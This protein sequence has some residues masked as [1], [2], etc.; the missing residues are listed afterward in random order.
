MS[1]HN[2]TNPESYYFERRQEMIFKCRNCGGNV[3]YS[4]EKKGMYCPYCDSENQD[5]KTTVAGDIHVCP[6]CGGELNMEEHTSAARCPYCEN[7]IIFDERVN[8]IYEPRF[9]IPFQ[10][11]RE[12]VKKLLKSKFKRNIFAPVDFL[13]EAKLNSM[14]GNYVPFWLYDYDT[15]CE[16]KGEGTKIRTWRAGEMEY[17]ETSY[18]HIYRNMDIFFQKIPVDASVK[19]SDNIMDLMEPYQYEQLMEFKPDYMSGFQGEKYNMDSKEVAFRARGKMEA[20]SKTMLNQSVGGYVR[21]RTIAEDVHIAR[22]AANYALLPVWL[23]QYQYNDKDYP[24]YING[25]TGKIIGKTP[26]SPGKV[27]GYGLTLWGVLTVIM[28]SI[29]VLLNLL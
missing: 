3:I 23:Y 1:D 19:M 6:D 17:T 13:S 12:M 11:S 20:D 21:I 5:D 25:Q 18:Y 8:G 16:Y 15:N 14:E 28:G 2:Q 22:E 27:F 10:H 4:P 7:Y 24:F 26:V 9:I 29:Y